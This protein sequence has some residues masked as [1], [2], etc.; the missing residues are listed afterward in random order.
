MTISENQHLQTLLLSKFTFK[1]ESSAL[2]DK[3]RITQ[4]LFVC[5][6]YSRGISFK[7]NKD[8]SS[9]GISTHALGTVYA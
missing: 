8:K 4:G 2:N 7:L 5:G 3:L 6:L 9:C 1:L